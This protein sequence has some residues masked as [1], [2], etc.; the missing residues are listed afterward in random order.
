[1]NNTTPS[2]NDTGKPFT[3]ADFDAV[4]SGTMPEGTVRMFKGQL[5]KWNGTYWVK[6]GG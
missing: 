5:I 1:M 6:S 3:Q 4:K 2:S